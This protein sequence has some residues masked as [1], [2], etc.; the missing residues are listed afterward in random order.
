MDNKYADI[1]CIHMQLKRDT[2][3]FFLAFFAQDQVINIS[4]NLI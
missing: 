2:M 4:Y 3:Q 1:H